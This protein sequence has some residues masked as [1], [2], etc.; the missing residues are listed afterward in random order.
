MHNRKKTNVAPSEAEVIALKKKAATYSSLIDVIFARRASED[1][2]Q[3]TFD[4][5]GKLIKMNPDFYSL[6]NFRKEIIIRKHFPLPLG[7]LLSGP[8]FDALRD[9]ELNLSTEGI[10]RN[11]KSCMFYPLVCIF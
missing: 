10:K 1:Y 5:V 7:G 4:A 2:S 6:W 11:P 8:E 9:E 3:E